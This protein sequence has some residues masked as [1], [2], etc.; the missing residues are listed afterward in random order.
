MATTQISPL[1]D[2]R[3]M[4]LAF[5]LG[6]RGVGR[7]WPNPAVGAVIVRPSEDGPVIVGRG[8]T[9]PGGRPHAETEAIA[10][11]GEAARGATLYVTLEPC[12]HFGQTPP[13]ADAI[14]AAGITRVVSA[15]DDPNPRVAGQ[16]HAR[17]RA[18]GIIVTTGVGIEEARRAHAAHIRRIRDNRPL[19]ILK[20]AV[21][22][23]G[24]VALEGRRPVQITGELARQQV[25]LLRA[26]SDAVIT[27]IGTVLADNP[28]LTCRL[29]GMETRSPVRIVLDSN[30]RFPPTSRMAQTAR[31]IPVCVFAGLAASSK[32]EEELQAVGVEVIRV[33]S[34]DGKLDLAAVLTRLGERGITRLMVEAG[35]IVSAAFLNS[36]LVDEAIL[37]RGPSAL[38]QTGIDAFD[39]LPLTALTRSPR[40]R[41]LGVKALGPDM[42]ERF[43]R[44]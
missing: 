2:A 39:G 7:T 10:R 31:G 20:T 9:Q 38:G 11:A 43:E 22:T 35:P 6:R 18:A 16:G 34:V 4:A 40:L 21:S 8:W 33:R 14:V 41:S 27:G 30:L 36:N 23:D 19:V 13:C 1:Y 32:A 29:P 44:T 3:F 28:Q 24:K 15:M 17:L 42:V 26:T 5:S 25:H 12:S 37:F